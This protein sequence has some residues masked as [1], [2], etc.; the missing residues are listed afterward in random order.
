MP[1]SERSNEPNDPK[2]QQVFSNDRSDFSIVWFSDVRISAFHC[3]VNVRNP[4]V[5]LSAFLKIVWFPNRPV[6][7]QCLIT[8][9]LH[10]DFERSV[11]SL[12]SVRLF[13]TKLDRFIYK[14]IICMTPLYIKWSSL[15]LKIRTERPKTKPFTVNGPNVR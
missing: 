2:S 8:G 5:R 1:K 11:H 15:A 4:D 6:I 7:R 13:L 3:T 14:N 10:S 9:R 12:Y